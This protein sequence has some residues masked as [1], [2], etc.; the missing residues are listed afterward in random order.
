MRGM[1]DEISLTSEALIQYWDL[2]T[3]LAPAERDG[4]S[5]YWDIAATPHV[6][7][8]NGLF[9]QGVPVYAGGVSLGWP[10]GQPEING[11]EAYVNQAPILTDDQILSYG[12]P[13]FIEITTFLAGLNYDIRSAPDREAPEAWFRNS[14]GVFAMVDPSGGTSTIKP[15]NTIPNTVF[16]PDE[17]GS[18]LGVARLETKIQEYESWL[19]LIGLAL[20]NPS[21]TPAET[22]KGTTGACNFS[23]RIYNDTKGRAGA[24]IDL[25]IKFLPIEHLYTTFLLAAAKADVYLGVDRNK[26]DTFDANRQVNQWGGS[27]FLSLSQPE[28]N[29]IFMAA[30][31]QAFAEWNFVGCDVAS[32]SQSLPCAV[33]V[34]QVPGYILQQVPIPSNIVE[35]LRSF[36]PVARKMGMKTINGYKSAYRRHY[37]IQLTCGASFDMGLI[38]PQQNGVD[39]GTYINLMFGNT[40]TMTYNFGSGATLPLKWQGP[41]VSTHSV[42]RGSSI[43]PATVHFADFIT[44]LSAY[45]YLEN[46]NASKN[47][48]WNTLNYYT[49]YLVYPEVVNPDE[50]IVMTAFFERVINTNPINADDVGWDL[51]HVLPVIYIDPNLDD[52]HQIGLSMFQSYYEERYSILYEPGTNILSVVGSKT[53][54]YVFDRASI[55]TENQLDTIEATVQHIG[56]GLWSG[57][58]NFFGKLVEKAPKIVDKATQGFKN[59]GIPGAIAGGASALVAGRHYTAMELLSFVHSA[60]KEQKRL[61]LLNGE[62]S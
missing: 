14:V 7:G 11:L 17:V 62:T 35:A 46:A 27:A 28:L 58:K 20:F 56:G 51:S 33:G 32:D 2:W 15:D 36:A 49:S 54:Q 38:F 24:Y 60:T 9:P 8:Q 5:F 23:D 40:T 52:V 43:V 30:V 48:L 26:A 42:V 25:F 13:A 16:S 34:L 39:L 57:V 21:R 41:F 55:T 29:Y 3:A 31:A 53:Q 10:S 61:I 47:T 4:Y 37:Y 19:A 44:R 18:L 6:M 1:R 59:G 22:Y 45:L 50:N 12:L